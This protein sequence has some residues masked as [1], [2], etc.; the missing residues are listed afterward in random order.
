MKKINSI[1]IVAS[2]YP[3]KEDPEYAFIRPVVCEMADLGID[4]TVFAPQSL[5]AK[6]KIRPKEWF[7]YTDQNNKI[8][9]VQ[10]MCVSLST[11]KIFEK[12]ISTQLK[13]K[14]LKRA[15]LRENSLPDAIYTHFWD[16]AVIAASLIKGI[17][18]YVAT[19]ESKI[20]VRERFSDKDISKA[21]NNISGV[22][23]VSTQ[24]IEE[25][26]ELGLIKNIEK[27]VV[28]PNGY[29]PSVF[30]PS[31]KQDARLKLGIPNESKIA[32][33]VG[34]FCERKGDQR[35]VEAAKAM[36]DLKLIMIG[37]G[38][39]VPKSD[40]II[41]C[42]TLPHGELV[43]YLNAADVFVLPTLAEG[44]CNAIVEAI[45][46]GLPIISSN[47]SFNDD[48]LDEKYSIRVN[49][50]SID[51]LSAALCKAFETPERLQ[52]MA[53]ES[54]KRAKSLT[55]KKRVEGIIDF[56]SK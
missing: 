8:R 36:P 56:M 14:C 27:T 7:D 17:P 25:S 6:K 20:W 24:K 49:P 41:Y 50:E 23:G 19:G 30:Y 52:K 4:C 1:W 22:I 39:K 13:T 34:D 48:I 44:C 35:V 31:S 2:G 18:I 16:N 21:L 26:I 32:I 11:I 43:N 54:R 38:D 37:K 51:E 15:F 47:R 42:G 33:F 5:K 53:N 9:V 55:V 10:P 29:N 40:Q 28:L 3:T 45:A 12:E 46:C